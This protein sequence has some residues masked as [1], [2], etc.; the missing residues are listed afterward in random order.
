[1]LKNLLYTCT[2]I[3][4][5]IHLPAQPYINS[6][7]PLKAAAGTA[8][9]ITGGGFNMVAAQNI[10]YFGQAKATVQAASVTSITVT[11]PFGATYQPITVTTGGL[12]A[13]SKQWFLPTFDAKGDTL[14][15]GSFYNAYS[16]NLYHNGDLAELGA[17]CVADF[18]GDGKPDIIVDESMSIYM[19]I[20]K[21]NSSNGNISF[22]EEAPIFTNE[23]FSSLIAAD[24]NGDGKTDIIAATYYDI[25]IYIN[26]SDGQ[27]ISF[28]GPVIYG[29]LLNANSAGVND[30]NLDGKPDIAVINNRSN[31]IVIF[32][33]TSTADSVILAP[34]INIETGGSP[35]SLVIADINQ[36]GLPD[37]IERNFDD[38]NF[39][40]FKNTS[41]NGNIAFAGRQNFDIGNYIYNMAAGDLNGDGKP[42]VIATSGSLFF[43]FTNTS[44]N[45]DISFAAKKAFNGGNLPNP[46]IEDAN[47]DGRPDV[48]LQGYNPGNM[49]IYQNA[50]TSDSIYLQNKT[51]FATT[52]ASAT[53]MADADSDGKPD[54]IM[55]PGLKI[56][57]F[58]NR[59][60]EV[61]PLTL[62]SFT[63]SKVKNTVQLHWQTVNEQ[64]T[65]G[66]TVERGEA[67]AAF[68]PIGLVPAAG[69]TTATKNYFFSD[70]NAMPGQNFY[71]LKMADAD[72]KYRYSNIIKIQAGTSLKQF[73]LYPNPAKNYVTISN[74][75]L[76]ENSL[77]KITD[78]AGKTIKAISLPAGITQSVINITGLAK[79]TYNVT[80]INTTNGSSTRLLVV[81]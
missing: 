17:T 63:G 4:L 78:M 36:D 56:N 54:F 73:M 61:L 68:Y 80:V 67:P 29:D 6:F 31:S 49:A 48:I 42:D 51:E 53:Y 76:N 10:V 69:N 19:R 64:N 3:L 62:L 22:K 12:T 1:M 23:D 74:L 57:I 40:I 66:F 32:K 72:G 52:Y 60:G 14:Q 15:N 21:N 9:T 11:V 25:R 20:F 50:S 59:V 27:S 70:E 41:S 24:I 45:G 37:L 43:V 55:L 16:Q 71:R 77:L 46:I 47:G 58:R 34:N 79:G 30:F 18:D 33:N 65:A 7:T 81:Q 28:A 38:N 35:G 5:C 13:Y 39:S 44:A 26:T 75:S 2:A 8:V